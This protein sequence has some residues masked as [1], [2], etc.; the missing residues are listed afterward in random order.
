[1]SYAL[2]NV[3][4]LLCI[5]CKAL[6][7]TC[8]RVKRLCLY[9]LC[10][11]ITSMTWIFPS[12]LCSQRPLPTFLTLHSLH[13]HSELC[14]GTICPGMVTQIRVQFSTKG[15]LCNYPPNSFFAFAGRKPFV[16]P[17]PL[18]ARR[19]LANCFRIFCIPA[20]DKGRGLLETHSAGT[21]S[22]VVWLIG[23]RG[24]AEALEQRW[25]QGGKRRKIP[26]FI[27]ENRLSL[28]SDPIIT[29]GMQHEVILYVENN[30]YAIGEN[31]GQ[32]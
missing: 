13:S 6:L 23:W 30:K 18:K 29:S 4:R 8:F 1:M 24:G 10:L 2:K 17:R 22:D 32:Q 3:Y 19:S 21:K 7:A 20:W 16:T 5:L 28:R 15:H 31:R 9:I 26:V 27:R 25:V 12:E 14:N 11:I